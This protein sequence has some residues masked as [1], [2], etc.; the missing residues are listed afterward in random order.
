MHSPYLSCGALPGFH[1]PAPQDPAGP[2][3]AHPAPAASRFDPQKST[4][5]GSDRGAV[6]SRLQQMVLF[7]AVFPHEAT[8]RPVRGIIGKSNM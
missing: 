1:L 3:A 6:R 7:E 5:S 4:V 8:F 2:L